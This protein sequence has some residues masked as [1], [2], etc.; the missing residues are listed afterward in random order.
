MTAQVARLAAISSAWLGP[1]TTATG[2]AGKISRRISLIRSPVFRSMPLAQETSTVD[3][4]SP[5][6]ARSLAVWRVAA[7][8]TPKSSSGCS[9]ASASRVDARTLPGRTISER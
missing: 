6:A 4:G 2:L 8:G 9:K 1:E 5:S 7:V 3:E